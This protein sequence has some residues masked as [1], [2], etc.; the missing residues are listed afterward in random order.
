MDITT[1]LQD[2]QLTFDAYLEIRNTED[3][4]MERADFE[5]FCAENE[6]I[7]TEAHR[8]LRDA[9]EE[10]LRGAESYWGP[11]GEYERREAE[12]YMNIEMNHRPKD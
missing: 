1:K 12:R 2:F 8:A 7:F 3:F 10:L 4:L 9:T 5:L 11:I 6:G